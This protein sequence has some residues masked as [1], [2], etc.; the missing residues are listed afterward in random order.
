VNGI[1]PAI[2]GLIALCVT[3]GTTLATVLWRGSALLTRLERDLEF[4]SKLFAEKLGTINDTSDRLESKLG[5]VDGIPDL[6]R[7]MAQIENIVSNEVKGRLDTIWDKLFSL[8]TRVAVAEERSKTPPPAPHARQP[9]Y[10]EID[11]DAP[12]PKQTPF[13]HTRKK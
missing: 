10:P 6:Q 4:Q 9:S 1:N 8:R 13:P 11:P 5:A 3:L 2:V 12:A 7:R